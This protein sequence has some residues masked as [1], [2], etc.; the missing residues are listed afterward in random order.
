MGIGIGDALT[1]FA[2]LGALG[3]VFPGLLLGW[4]LIMPGAV[5]RAHERISRTPWKSLLL[6]IFAL[7]I[8]GLPDALLLREAGPL[9]F[10]GFVGLFILLALASIGAA[11]LA[12]MMGE[13]LRGHGVQV[14]VP[15]A[16]VRGAIALEFAVIFPLIG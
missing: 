10:F 1:V 3:F 11:G 7:I 16:L 6:G 12:G 8:A 5:G 15:G 14:T 2:I 9:Q 13:R 4:S